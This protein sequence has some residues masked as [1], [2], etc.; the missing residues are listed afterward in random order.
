MYFNTLFIKILLSNV[1][2]PFQN[3][4]ILLVN[5][6]FLSNIFRNL[7][8]DD[9]D[10]VFIIAGALGRFPKSSAKILTELKIEEE[11]KPFIQRVY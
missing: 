10:D 3:I 7:F 5:I 8:D 1:K 9:D 4:Y 11:V 6:F 2:L